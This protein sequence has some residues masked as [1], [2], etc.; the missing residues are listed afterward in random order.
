MNNILVLTDFSDIAE[1]GVKVAFQ[2]CKMNDAS[3][4]IFHHVDEGHITTIELDKNLQIGPDRKNQFPPAEQYK[5]WIK[6][7]ENLDIPARYLVGG[8]DL[9]ADVNTIAL[10]IQAD[11]IIL[12]STGIG[13]VD[14]PTWGSNTQK[15]VNSSSHPVLIIKQKLKD[16]QLESIVFASS[17]DLKERNVLKDFLALL[18]PPKDAMIHFLSVDTSASFSQPSILIHEV[19]KDFQKLALPWKSS[20]HFYEGYSIEDGIKRF[21]EEVKPD[22]LVMSTKTGKPIKHFFQG[23][24]AVNL[25]THS[26][27]P[28]LII[29]HRK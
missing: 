1:Y 19:Q 17:F 12:G 7:S 22:M 13:G 2:Y 28:V 25:A 15:I 21:L 27:F 9:V 4:T 3:L 5:K 26:D 24:H 14:K 23:N 6:M 11:L 20:T 10:Q 16:K 8:D 29:P 18:Q